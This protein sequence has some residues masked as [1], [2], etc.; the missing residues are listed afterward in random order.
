M[1]LLPVVGPS[2]L[3]VNP[4]FEIGPM[5]PRYS[6]YF[7]FEGVSV[8]ENGAR[9][10]AAASSW[11]DSAWYGDPSIVSPSLADVGGGGLVAV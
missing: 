3:S 6:E 8:D 7:V 10:S 11:V 1:K 4:I 5:E 9:L 2:P